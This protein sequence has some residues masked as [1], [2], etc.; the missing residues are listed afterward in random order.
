M[1]SS[2]Y[3]AFPGGDDYETDIS[4]QLS[5]YLPNREPI[6]S[7][8]ERGYILPSHGPQTI[9]IDTINT[10]KARV[11]VI[12]IPERNLIKSLDDSFLRSLTAGKSIG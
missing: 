11:V 12:R 2:Y 6:I 7:F 10:T 3:L 4:E 5:V 1:N 8:R 9:P